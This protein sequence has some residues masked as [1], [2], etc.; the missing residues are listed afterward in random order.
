MTRKTNTTLGLTAA[1]NTLADLD[2][3]SLSEG[4]AKLL[5][6]CECGLA[7]LEMETSGDERDPELAEHAKAAFGI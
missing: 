5:D 4:Q 6:A 2:R 3:A 7:M 1:L